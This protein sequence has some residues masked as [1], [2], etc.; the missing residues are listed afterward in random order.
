[1]DSKI[2][3]SDAIYNNTFLNEYYEGVSQKLF[4]TE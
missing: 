4:I 2:A 3:Y 1:M